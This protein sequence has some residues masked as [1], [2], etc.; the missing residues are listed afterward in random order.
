MGGVEEEEKGGGGCYMVRGELGWWV[1]V[2]VRGREGV[3][4]GRKGHMEGNG[5]D[6]KEFD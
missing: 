6:L 4:E 3:D 5:S 1:D 2:N